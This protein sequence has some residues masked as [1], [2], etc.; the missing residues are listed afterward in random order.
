MT[1]IAFLKDDER[2][3]LRKLGPKE[4]VAAVQGLL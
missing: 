3:K 4:E 2:A 1:T